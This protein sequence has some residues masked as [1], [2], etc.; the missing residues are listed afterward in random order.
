ML[1]ISHLLVASTIVSS[2]I[3]E[4]IKYYID[5]NYIFYIGIFLGSILP[6]IDEPNSILGKKFFFLSYYINRFFG[7]RGVTHNLIFI[8]LLFVIGVLSNIDILIA[9]TLGMAIHIL[10]DAITYQGIKGSLYPLTSRNYKFVILPD[11]LRFKVGGSIEYLLV[12]FMCLYHIYLF[13]GV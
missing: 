3:I 9:I 13:V 7:H 4:Y 6:D 8:L 5:I 12:V 2:P 1:G 11:I 10:T